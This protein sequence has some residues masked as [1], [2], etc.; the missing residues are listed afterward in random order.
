MSTEDS[1]DSFLQ[2]HYNSYRADGGSHEMY[3]LLNDIAHDLGDKLQSNYA[4]K[5]ANDKP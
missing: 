2:A 4:L 5:T 1:F 3:V